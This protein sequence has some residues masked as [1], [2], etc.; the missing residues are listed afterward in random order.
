[1]PIIGPPAP[2]L[3]YSIEIVVHALL[4]ENYAM[5]PLGDLIW[6]G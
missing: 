6:G 2:D 3:D 5:T 4:F 1:M